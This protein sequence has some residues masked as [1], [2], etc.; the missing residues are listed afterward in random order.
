[1]TALPTLVKKLITWGAAP[2]NKAA[3]PE[4]MTPLRP[5]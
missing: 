1:L 2:I 5:L 3:A 4:M